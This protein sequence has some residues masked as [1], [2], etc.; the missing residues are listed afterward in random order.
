MENIPK[1]P[2]VGDKYRSVLHPGAHCKVIN[3]FDGQVLFQWL[4]QNAFIQEHSLPIKRFV[5]IFQF[6]EAKPEV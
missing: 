4:E 2:V 5:T 1:L 3:V 6:C